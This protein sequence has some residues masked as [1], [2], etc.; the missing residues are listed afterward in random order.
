MVLEKVNY[1]FPD[2]SKILHQS[3][4]A[5]RSQWSRGLRYEMSS[6]AQ[7]LR[8]S[9]RSLVETWMST[10]VLCLHFHV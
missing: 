4:N 1:N 6:P 2:S 10:F 7:A 5:Y 3:I 8:S 9:V